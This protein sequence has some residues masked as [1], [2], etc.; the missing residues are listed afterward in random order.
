MRIICGFCLHHIWTILEQTLKKITVP[1]IFIV[2]GKLQLRWGKNLFLFLKYFNLFTDHF[3][4]EMCNF[5]L[6]Q[7]FPPSLSVQVR[8]PLAGGVSGRG[9]HH[10]VQ[11]VGG[12]VAGASCGGAPR[13]AQPRL[14]HQHHQPLRI[15]LLL[16]IPG[17]DIWSTYYP[18][19]F[20]EC[21]F[22]VPSEG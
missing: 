17:Y 22:P 19:F 4:L 13:G 21:F 18:P 5:L 12:C 14:L 1:Y 15:H 16:W 8:G 2:G 7:W 6:Y 9:V 10:G 3:P 20:E 11:Q